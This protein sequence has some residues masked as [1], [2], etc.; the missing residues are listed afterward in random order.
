MTPHE[1]NFLWRL[2]LDGPMTAS[3]IAEI[4]NR[5][6]HRPTTATGASVSNQLRRLVADGY[7]AG[8]GA[9]PQTYH[10]T[11]AGLAYVDA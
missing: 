5:P 10:L 3:E 4:L 2:K 1:F 11:D 9:R 6:L 7:V 8:D